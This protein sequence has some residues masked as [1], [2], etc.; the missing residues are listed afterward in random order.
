VAR[1]TLPRKQQRK[2]KQMKT[3]RNGALTQQLADDGSIIEAKSYDTCIVTIATGAKSE[4]IFNATKYS[5]T[6]SR[7]QS[8]VLA[9]ITA[10]LTLWGEKD[11]I[12][13]VTNAPRGVSAS[14]LRALAG[15]E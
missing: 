2:G 5:S 6:T 1:G 8:K 12:V 9:K 13:K 4:Y 10:T 15:K 7:Q 3:Q 11:G 14:E